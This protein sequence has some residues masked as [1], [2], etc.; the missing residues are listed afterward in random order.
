[1][2]GNCS[3]DVFLYEQGECQDP[4]HDHFWHCE[5]WA[6]DRAPVRWV[7][8][9][10]TDKREAERARVEAGRAAGEPTASMEHY[11]SDGI[12]VQLWVPDFC[13]PD[14]AEF[15]SNLWWCSTQAMHYKAQY[16]GPR[17]TRAS[18]W[19][20][21]FWI[22]QEASLLAEREPILDRRDAG[23]EAHDL[24]GVFPG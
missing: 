5:N 7:Y 17:A 20:V 21:Q 13:V 15:A 3:V 10:N 14:N 18:I 24:Q 16:D 11:I 4:T 2:A 1:M 19:N 9:D 8:R 12:S 6:G 22:K 23:R